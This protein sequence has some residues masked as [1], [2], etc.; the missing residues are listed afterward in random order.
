MEAGLVL[1][2]VNGILKKDCKGMNS[3]FPVVPAMFLFHP[4]TVESFAGLPG[5]IW[6][7]VVP[8]L[9][10]LSVKPVSYTHLMIHSSVVRAVPRTAKPARKAEAQTEPEAM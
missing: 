5:T 8:I 6:V 3:L 4:F 10:F 1:A 7:I 9:L 2:S